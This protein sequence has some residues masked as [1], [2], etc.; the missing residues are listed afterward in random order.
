MIHHAL[1]GLT[2]LD[3]AALIVCAILILFVI[4]LPE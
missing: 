2:G 1:T 4:T 3:I